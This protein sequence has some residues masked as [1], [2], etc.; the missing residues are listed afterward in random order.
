MCG[1]SG[2]LHFDVTR[3]VD[4]SG[5][6]KMRDS[7]QH[8]GPDGAG[9]FI[10]KEIG[11]AHRRLSIID[12]SENARQPFYS[13]DGRY[14]MVF[15]GEIFNYLELRKEFEKDGDILKSHSD[16]E[17]LLRLY[18]KYGESCLE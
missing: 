13:P 10:D 8:R 3:K 6:L 16:T 17:V 15:N 11:L 4:E 1:I 18:I 5:L 12:I 7:L 2:I 9:F 14:V